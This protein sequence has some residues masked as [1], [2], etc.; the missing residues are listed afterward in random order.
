M[1]NFNAASKANTAQSLLPSFSETTDEI[2]KSFQSVF[3][4]IK[5]NS[6]NTSSNKHSNNVPSSSPYKENNS[7]SSYS[8]SKT[9]NNQVKS[10]YVKNNDDNNDNAK[11]D[12][13]REN[14]EAVENKVYRDDSITNIQETGTVKEPAELQIKNIKVIQNNQKDNTQENSISIKDILSLL[15]TAVNNDVEVSN[16]EEVTQANIGK[17]SNNIDLTLSQLNISD[18]LKIQLQNT[19][20]L[21]ENISQ[22]GLKQLAEYISVLSKDINTDNINMENISLEEISEKILG[23]EVDKASLEKAYTVLEE[24]VSEII[25][26]EKV[27]SVLKENKLE[28]PNHQVNTSNENKEDNIKPEPSTSFVENE[29][30]SATIIN[31]LSSII[32]EAVKQ[33]DFASNDEKLELAKNIIASVQTAVENIL[34]YVNP[35]DEKVVNIDVASNNIQKNIPITKDELTMQ[36]EFLSENVLDIDNETLNKDTNVKQVIETSDNLME[37]DIDSGKQNVEKISKETLKDVIKQIDATTI[38]DIQKEFKTANVEVLESLRHESSVKAEAKASTVTFTDTSKNLQNNINQ[39]EMMI[40]QN[41]SEEIFSTSQNDKGNNFNYFLKSSAEAQAKYD[42]AQSQEDNA[43]YNMK[44]PRDIE[45]LV[46]TMQS[47]VSKG[48]SKLTVVLTPE[49]LG[50]MQIHLSESGGKITAKFLSD[51]ENSHKL[52]MAQSDLLKNQLSEKGIV[53]DNMEFAYSD[54]M[55]KQHSNDEQGRK[56][57]KQAQKNKNLKNQD[58]NLEVGTEVASNKATGIY[59]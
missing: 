5:D 22:D 29:I 48:Q 43:P 3:N 55:S 50:R 49:N 51:N 58:D 56:A 14:Y 9:N 44:E 19:I 32:D 38:K 34:E 7:Y 37:E 47:S 1:I 23:T 24:K 27:D 59:A 52:I 4:S 20:S 25:P 36:N 39:K 46:R 10:Q 53:V 33:V 18:D 21:L 26:K 42:T 31:N 11:L 13:D 16:D 6:Y 30:D 54:A 28:I 57:S 12:T 35:Y 45:R 8:D 17:V 40:S 2:G 41:S 15:Q